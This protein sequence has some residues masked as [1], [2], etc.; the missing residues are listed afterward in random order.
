[1]PD[2]ASEFDFTNYDYVVDAIDTVSGKLGIIKE[3]YDKNIPIISSMGAGNK[4]NPQ[5]F[6]VA[7]INK[8]EVDPLA[9]TIRYEVRKLGIK[10]L[11]VVYSKEIPLECKIKKT[12]EETGKVIP[13]SNPFVPS[14]CGL[15]IASEVTK[16]LLK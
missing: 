2:T 5:G 10:H 7:D 4:L 11:K 6:I 1:M 13:G 14:S 16:D 12:S 3:A 8:T 15:L 9:R